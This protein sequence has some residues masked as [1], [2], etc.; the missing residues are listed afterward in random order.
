MRNLSIKNHTILIIT[1]SHTDAF[2][3]KEFLVRYKIALS[4]NIFTYYTNMYDLYDSFLEIGGTRFERKRFLQI[5]RQ[6]EKRK[7]YQSVI[8]KRYTEIFLS[9]NFNPQDTRYNPTIIRRMMRYLDNPVN[10][11]MFLNYPSIEAFN[12]AEELSGENYLTRIVAGDELDNRNY[13]LK[14]GQQIGYTNWKMSDKSE[15]DRM[16]MKNLMKAYNIAKVPYKE[17]EELVKYSKLDMYEILNRQVK[18]FRDSGKLF[19]LCTSIFI[20]LELQER[21]AL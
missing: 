10:G 18:K 13:R 14:V 2:L 19:T 8:R 17:G 6:K 11:M 16:F 15:L 21:P 5:L 7:N 3:I 9:Y 12:D 1:E 4:D 20:I